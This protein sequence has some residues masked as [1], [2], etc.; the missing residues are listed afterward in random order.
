MLPDLPSRSAD[1]QCNAVVVLAA[2]QHFVRH[3]QPRHS[4]PGVEIGLV[5]H[6][7]EP[8]PY[9]SPTR[10]FPLICRA[11]PLFADVHPAFLPQ[12]VRNAAFA[13]TRKTHQNEQLWPFAKVPLLGGSGAPNSLLHR[14]KSADH[15]RPR[16]Q[17]LQQQ[18]LSEPARKAFGLRLGRLGHQNLKQACRLD[19]LGI[20]SGSLGRILR[21]EKISA[22]SIAY[23]K[24]VVRGCHLLRCTKLNLEGVRQAVYA[25]HWF[26]PNPTLPSQT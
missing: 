18:P 6:H 19:T 25:A 24:H 1:M 23:S 16:M 15:S 22:D 14:S 4:L 13:R 17:S 3:Q 12:D 5:N 2:A 7:V 11:V 26:A 21:A 8:F 20:L 10:D 9:A